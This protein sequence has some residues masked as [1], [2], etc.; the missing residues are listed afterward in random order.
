MR[1][2]SRELIFTLNSLFRGPP[3]RPQL[4]W[5]PPASSK[6]LVPYTQH[7]RTVFSRLTL[8]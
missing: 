6:Q 8:Q 1:D 3:T 2:G 7:T 4:T 5:Q